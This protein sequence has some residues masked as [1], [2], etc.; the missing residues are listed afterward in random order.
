VAQNTIT[1]HGELIKCVR[2]LKIKND[3]GSLSTEDIHID[4]CTYNGCVRTFV[5]I[6]IICVCSNK[7]TNMC[8]YVYVSIY[9]IRHYSY[10]QM[11]TFI[12]ACAYTCVYMYDIYVYTYLCSCVFVCVGSRVCVCV[13][14]HACVRVRTYVDI[15]RKR[16][17]IP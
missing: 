4:V 6:C 2:R 10:V 16:K 17:M 12:C 8:V 5:H 11:Y 9:I 7:F 14:A 3:M 1:T 15:H 13:R